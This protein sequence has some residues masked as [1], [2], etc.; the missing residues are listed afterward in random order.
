MK[1]IQT[2]I[3]HQKPTHTIFFSNSNSKR[4]L[5]KRGYCIE[6]NYIKLSLIK[7]ESKYNS[8][9]NKIYNTT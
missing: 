2:H 5:F 3:I 6:T 1:L 8:V 7:T 4:I 9:K